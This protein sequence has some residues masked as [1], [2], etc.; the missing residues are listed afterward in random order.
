MK[1]MIIG[2]ALGI[3]LSGAACYFALPK[4]KQAAYDS[5]YETG[6]KQGIA[7]GTT[8]GITQ[9]ISE[10]LA[11]QK[12]AHDSLTAIENKKEASRKA[13]QKQKEKE[14]LKDI[15]NWH[16]VDGRVADPI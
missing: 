15:Q 16:V 4:V 3:V 1:K 10:I 7:T 2:L 11:K 13:A 9:G 8:A 14:E 5:G 6:N 12:H